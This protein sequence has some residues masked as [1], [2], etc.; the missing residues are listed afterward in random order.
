MKSESIGIVIEKMQDFT[1]AKSSYGCYIYTVRNNKTKQDK[2]MYLDYVD[3]YAPNQ[4]KFRKWQISLN[5]KSITE[6][7]C[8]LLFNENTIFF[9]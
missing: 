7:E 9:N 2:L 1:R 6:D 8:I 4:A 5:D 3:V